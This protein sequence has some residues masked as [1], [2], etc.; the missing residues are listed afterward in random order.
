MATRGTTTQETPTQSTSATAAAAATTTIPFVT[1]P[2]DGKRLVTVPNAA[3][4]TNVHPRT[5]YGW[6]QRGLVEVRLLPSGVRRVVVE[7]LFTQGG[8]DGSANR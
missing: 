5:V 4:L 3:R 2:V 6:I 8:R 7:S 1:D